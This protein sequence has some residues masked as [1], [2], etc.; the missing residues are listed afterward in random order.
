M[1]QAE[2]RIE[3]D[4]FLPSPDGDRFA[5]GPQEGSHPGNPLEAIQDYWDAH[6][7]E[8]TRSHKTQGTRDYFKDIEMRRYH[9]A[10]HIPDFADFDS[11]RG[12]A[13]LEVGCGIGTDTVNFGRAGADVTAVDISE[14][15][16]TLAEQRAEVYGLEDRITFVL[17]NVET[18][19]KF[20][21]P[22]RFDL[23][24]AFGTLSH[25]PS[26]DAALKE[27]H[28]LVKP[29][30]KLKIMVYNRRSLRVLGIVLFRG[31]GC[32]WRSDRLVN[33][34]GLMERGCPVTKVFSRRQARDL[35]EGAGFKVTRISAD[36]IYPYKKSSERSLKFTRKWRYSF[37]P[38]FLFRFLE[39]RFGWHLLIEA[40]A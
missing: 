20:L 36:H 6:P 11:W 40:E 21:G 31:F 28:A 23:A 33:R 37:I 35:V 22:A 39:R 34:Y 9:L 19:A 2:V 24:Y 32:F 5:Q 13:V 15:S 14:T 18:L 12:A 29:G 4:D 25:T 7:W 38:G 17:G 10:P 8:A 30:G 3:P 27:L 16:A 1:T 26:A